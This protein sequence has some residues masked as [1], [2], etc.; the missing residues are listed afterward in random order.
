MKKNIIYISKSL[1]MDAYEKQNFRYTVAANKFNN[2]LMEGFVKNGCHVTAYLFPVFE[3]EIK[4]NEFMTMHE[5]GIDYTLLKLKN[6]GIRAKAT[7]LYML[8]KALLRECENKD[9]MIICDYLNYSYA[10]VALLVSRRKHIA[11][12]T[13]VT[14]LPQHI[15]DYDM[16]E[17]H[18]WKETAIVT[19][20]NKILNS[21]HYY[22]L[23]SKYMVD[24]IAQH[25]YEYCVVEGLVSDDFAGEVKGDLGENIVYCGSLHKK[26][27]I[28]MLIDGFLLSDHGEKQLHIYG[29]GDYAD[30]IRQICHKECNVCF[31]GTLPHK[32][33][34]KVQSSAYLLVNPR[35]TDKEFVKY[36]FPSK[37]M[38]YMLSGTPVLTTD[39]PSMPEDYKEYIH[40]IREESAEGIRDILNELYAVDNTVLKKKALECRNYVLKN[41]NNKL[42]AK[43]FLDI[44]E[45]DQKAHEYL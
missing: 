44:F 29:D 8:Y 5:N 27:G 24:K 6:R 22:L 31:H 39:L 21:F 45:G 35:P 33:I 38:E 19:I 3:E 25:K 13:V 36:S 1:P 40:L 17:K 37:N 41:K 26:Y 30:T 11:I 34:L 9:T 42:Q 28:D 20:G 12:G 4:K 18:S 16:R 2:H 15:G 7:T 32:E 43:R 23:L 14:D 10:L